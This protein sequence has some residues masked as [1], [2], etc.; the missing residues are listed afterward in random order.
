MAIINDGKGRRLGENALIDL[1]LLIK[2]KFVSKEYKTGSTTAYKTLSDNDLTDELKQKYDA[3]HSHSTAAHAPT[4][5]QANII[6]A[7]KVN[8]TALN[9][10]EKTVDIAIPLMSTDI[11]ADKTSTA[12]TASAKAVFD[13]VSAALAGAS[14][15]SFNILES[16]QYDAETG[17][18]TI[19]GAS[20]FIYLVPDENSVNNVYAEYIYVNGAFECIGKTAVDLDGYLKEEDLVEY[21]TE[22]M[23]AIWSSVFNS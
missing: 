22:E 16:G 23:N 13:Y 1:L 18:P 4:D 17:V 9:I 7:V 19:E 20:N 5:A 3:A 12:K 6:E 8:G 15:L 2:N 21:T 11:A 14:S 10:D